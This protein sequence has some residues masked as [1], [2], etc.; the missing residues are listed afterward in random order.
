MAIKARKGDDEREFSQQQWDVLGP[1]KRGWVQIGTTEM[2]SINGKPDQPRFIPDEIVPNIQNGKVIA[3]VTSATI[4]E[5]K[6]PAGEKPEG[7][8]KQLLDQEFTDD[9]ANEASPAGGELKKEIPF[10]IGN[11]EEITGASEVKEEVKTEK[12][13][14]AKGKSNQGGAK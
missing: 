4:T 8:K 14:S 2:I 6:K 5:V 10:S 12:A 7:E 13:A 9:N 11:P 3:P 1:N